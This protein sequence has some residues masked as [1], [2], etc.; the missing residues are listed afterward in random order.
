MTTTRRSFPSANATPVF[1][2]EK[3]SQVFFELSFCLA[4]QEFA[5]TDCRLEKDS[6]LSATGGEIF[7]VTAANRRRLAVRIKQQLQRIGEKLVS[8][9]ISEIASM[10]E[11]GKYPIAE[12]ASGAAIPVLR[13][14]AH[15]S[16]KLSH[17][18]WLIY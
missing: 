4:L 5:E 11:A 14:C 16:G 17:I 7:G 1:I 18:M 2:F 3:N 10:P 12:N 8:K 15:G 9:K 6:P 13:M